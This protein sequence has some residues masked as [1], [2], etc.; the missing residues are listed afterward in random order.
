MKIKS[1]FKAPVELKET[2]ESILIPS[3]NHEVGLRGKVELEILRVV[4]NLTKSHVVKSHYSDVVIT[5]D[6]IEAHALLD[7]LM[8]NL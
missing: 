4:V 3:M 6:E 1:E 2:K 5:L 8:E 7:F